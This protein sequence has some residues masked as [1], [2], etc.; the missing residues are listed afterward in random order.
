[1]IGTDNMDWD[2]S[3]SNTIELTPEQRIIDQFSGCLEE[4]EGGRELE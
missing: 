4:R 3:G 1:M 2:G